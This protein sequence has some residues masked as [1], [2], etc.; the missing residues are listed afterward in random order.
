MLGIDVSCRAAM[1]PRADM[2]PRPWT[3][4]RAGRAPMFAIILR[5]A[6]RRAY[7]DRRLSHILP[8]ARRLLRSG[9]RAA[10][11][12]AM[13]YIRPA[14][15]VGPA[16][17]EDHRPAATGSAIMVRKWQGPGDG[18]PRSPTRRIDA[19]SVSCAG[20]TNWVRS[21]TFDDRPDSGTWTL[22]ERLAPRRRKLTFRPN[23]AARRF[24]QIV[25]RA[26]T[27]GHEMALH[28][29]DRSAP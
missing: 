16:H 7:A 29:A 1:V 13:A 28:G 8:I 24:P 2:L 3:Y 12:P 21:L 6:A 10:K 19:L 18:S 25:A 14:G 4:Q 22:L 15:A 26:L 17:L 23:S 5:T 11:G 20:I 27:G 9:G